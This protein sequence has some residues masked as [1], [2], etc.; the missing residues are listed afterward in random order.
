MQTFL[1]YRDFEQTA[2][3][4]DYRRLGKQ[5]VEAYQILQIVINNVT[6]SRWLNHPAVL[7]WKNFPE[8]LA[9]YG[10]AI[11][12]EW[13]LRGYKDNLLIVFEN[14]LVLSPKKKIEYPFWLGLEEF[15][16]KHRAALL[17]KDFDWYSQFGWEEKPEVNYMWPVRMK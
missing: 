2:N 7:M 11:C 15:H 13:I 1:P 6:K 4:L 5:R 8:A 9:E 10:K 14:F 3:C 12:K 16:S 17:A